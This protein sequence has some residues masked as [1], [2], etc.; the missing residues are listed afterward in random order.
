MSWIWNIKYQHFRHYFH[1][2]LRWVISSKWDCDAKTFLVFRLLVLFFMI[3]C[4]VF[5][6][7]SWL[8]RCGLG[9]GGG[10]NHAT[11]IRGFTV[12]EPSPYPHHLRHECRIQA[13]M[14]GPLWI[15][16][17]SLDLCTSSWIICAIHFASKDDECF[18]V[19]KYLLCSKFNLHV[20]PCV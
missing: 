8:M 3:I 2:R 10:Y 15:Y 20:G 17:M 4:G 19:S 7:P 12:G 13:H 11:T 14:R 9:G 18:C 5:H 1:L 6:M 16:V